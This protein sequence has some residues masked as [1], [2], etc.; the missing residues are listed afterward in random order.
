[1]SRRKRGRKSKADHAK[2]RR[3]QPRID[4]SFAKSTNNAS[5]ATSSSTIGIATN[6]STNDTIGAN[7]SKSNNNNDVMNTSFDSTDS[8]F[9]DL[10]LNSIN[11]DDN[12]PSENT[13]TI[14]SY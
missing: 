8:S 2:E 4:T 11:I 10:V 12:V 3:V 1:M 14:F 9:A 5:N 7:E 6:D 13:A